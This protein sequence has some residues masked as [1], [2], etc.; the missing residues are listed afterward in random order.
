MILTN[1][2]FSQNYSY[3]LISTKDGLPSSTITGI[4]KD[5]NGVIWVGTEK[6]LC[7]ISNGQ[8]R[9]FKGLPDEG[10]L[11]VFA[12]SDGSLWVSFGI[13]QFLVKIK[14]GKIT[15]YSKEKDAI[16]NGS[17]LS[18]FEKNK[19]IYL[20]Q[21]DGIT[22]VSPDGKFKPL[23][24][25]II[26]DTMMSYWTIDFFTYN[27][28]VYSSNL[29]RGI[30]E[31]I[32]RDKDVIFKNVFTGDFIYGSSCVNNSLLLTF[33][34]ETKLFD[35]K[36]FL[37]RNY[38]QP[39]KTLS[40]RRPATFVTDNKSNI[41]GGCYNINYG[42]HGLIKLNH[43]LKE[44]L[45]L[46]E[47]I[48]GQELF[49]DQSTNEIYFGTGFGLYIVNASF[50]SR[51][52]NFQTEKLEIPIISSYP[53]KN[54]LVALTESGLFQLN[55][56][57]SIRKQLSVADLLAFVNKQQTE[58]S[59]SLITKSY[60]NKDKLTLKGLQLDDLKLVNGKWII[61]SRIG[62]FII[63]KQF[64]IESFTPISSSNLN[65]TA[66]GSLIFDNYRL[67]LIALTTFPKQKILYDCFKQDQ[68]VLKHLMGIERFGQKTIIITENQGVFSFEGTSL[69][70]I[71]LTNLTTD[72]YRCTSF[73]GRYLIISTV[74]GDILFYDSQANFKLVKTIKKSSF[75]NESIIDLKG[76]EYYLSF[77]TSKRL[78]IWD[79]K[80]LKS[81]NDYQ[82]GTDLFDRINLNQKQL[83]IY[84]PKTI[85]RL[86]LVKLLSEFKSKSVFTV[87]N[88]FTKAKEPIFN[89]STH[90]FAKNRT[91]TLQFLSYNELSA[92]ILKGYYRV[93]QGN[94]IEIDQNGKINLQNLDY[95]DT[96]IEFKVFDKSSGNIAWHQHYTITAPTPWYLHFLA[97]TFYILLF[98]ACLILLTRYF[99]V[100]SK[101]KEI[102]RLTISNKINSLQ[103]EAL[104]SQ[105]NPHFVFNALN[106]MQKFIL[107]ID[108]E[109]ALLFLN[110]FSVLIRKVLDFS[111]LKSIII[112][113][114][115]EFLN[116]YLSVENQRFQD[117]IKLVQEISCDTE[118]MIPPLLIQPLIENAIIYGLRNEFA[119]MRISLAITEEETMLKI[120]VKNEINPQ[121]TKNHSFQSKSTEIIQKRLALYDPSASLK[122]EIQDQLFIAIILLPIND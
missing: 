10:V 101:E 111:S 57:N 100:K 47:N 122:T 6:G 48:P 63:N 115:L 56:S 30:N 1:F 108:Q 33:D 19:H 83:V 39:I 90:F 69:K 112:E 34:P 74:K 98:S 58:T 87:T 78:Y 11:S 102:E 106:S 45:I 114:E 70:Q 119:E 81:H 71:K 80:K 29:L 4:T 31:V 121:M 94:W 27:N 17:V 26:S 118:I 97:I 86:D 116:L 3:K 32:V 59:N 72:V 22:V 28:K 79:G 66:D 16:K 110:Q 23:V 88:R 120:V 2:S 64:K 46:P 107:N 50:Y 24:N 61:F 5:K 43:K 8:I 109:K 91:I 49:Y 103:M 21:N 95:G 99:V 67:S 76:N 14:D 117:S 75:F 36:K 89:K 85:I 54:G 62:F 15:S 104:Q 42:F 68:L 41:F 84:S 35:A 55:L 37:S 96:E 53:E 65:F 92:E 7:Y 12:S 52:F 93:N 105:M 73:Q 82:S 18:M 13:E 51:F 25:K 40:S 60:I 113:E 9:Q 20:A 38:Q 44:E 77:I